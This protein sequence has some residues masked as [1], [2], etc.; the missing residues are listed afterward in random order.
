MHLGNLDFSSAREVYENG[1]HSKSFATLGLLTAL[2]SFTPQ[3]TAVTGTSVDGQPVSGK[4]YADA[5]Q[6]AMQLQVQYATKDAQDSYVRC[7][8]GGSSEAVTDGCK[9]KSFIRC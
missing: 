9:L 6:G 1:S 7:Q 8:V 4:V 2:E 5:Q 3:G